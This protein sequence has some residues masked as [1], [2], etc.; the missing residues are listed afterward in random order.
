LSVATRER[1]YDR[2]TERGRELINRLGRELREAR[3]DRGLSLR[4]TAREA[5]LSAPTLSRIERG[6]SPTVSFMTVARLMAT[7]GLELSARAYPGG[8]P[9]RDAPQVDLLGELRAELHRTL[10]WATEV[11]LPALGD[12]RAWDATVSGRG[13]IYGVEAETG[14]R[15]AQALARRIALK[16]RDSN[17]DGV[18]LL[19][20]RGRRSASFLHDARAVLTPN[21]PQDGRRAVELLRAGLDP[22]GSAIVVL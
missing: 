19:L 4:V 20:R 1:R 5:R 18:I 2:G 21:F 17:V 14:P 10:R 12:L 22:G 9:L 13:W 15:D 16:Q 7:V 8:Q 3:L 6:R 11:P